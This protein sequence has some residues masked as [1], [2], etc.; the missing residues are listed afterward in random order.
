M[1]RKNYP[2]DNL[3][4]F[5]LRLKPEIKDQL[6]DHARQ[7]GRSLNAEINHRLEN[8]LSQQDND[9][10]DLDDFLEKLKAL[11]ETGKG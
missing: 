2:S 4:Q 5:N 9:P 7:S 11:I 3:A 1:I 8:S 6:A 10:G